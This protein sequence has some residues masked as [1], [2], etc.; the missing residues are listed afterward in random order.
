MDDPVELAQA[1]LSHALRRL[2]ELREME[3][4]FNAEPAI[5]PV[6]EETEDRFAIRSETTR[7]PDVEMGLTAGDVIHSLRAALDNLY[8]GFALIKAGSGNYPANARASFPIY[9][10]KVKRGNRACWDVDGV[11]L[12][13]AVSDDVAT[14]MK[15]LQPFNASNP[16]TEY[17]WV[18][19]RL[20]NDDKHKRIF[21]TVTSVLMSSVFIKTMN[22]VGMVDYGPYMHQP[23]P[24]E[25]G[26]ILW[27]IDLVP[28]AK[29]ELD[30]EFNVQ[31]QICF[32][33]DGPGKGF[34]LVDTLLD[35]QA[36]LSKTVVPSLPP[37]SNS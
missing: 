22:I 25:N 31:W 27:G 3:T 37:F 32:P 23:G 8:W 21:P 14:V 19:D 1:R 13:N 18:L 5:R 6:K 2:H 15:R 20:W 12:C 4:A 28:P 26:S 11:K 9:K 29:V 10:D 36:Y 17:L 16:E 35:M 34:V 30:A 33:P 7:Q 24:I